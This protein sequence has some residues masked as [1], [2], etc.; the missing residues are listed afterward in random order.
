M[1]WKVKAKLE[2]REGSVF[3]GLMDRGVAESRA[4]HCSAE[5]TS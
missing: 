1:L 3:R 5:R 4:L 2:I